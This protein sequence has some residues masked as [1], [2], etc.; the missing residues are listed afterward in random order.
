[1]YMIDVKVR[2][3]FIILN[4]DGLYFYFF[5]KHSIFFYQYVHELI[6]RWRQDRKMVKRHFRCRDIFA[7]VNQI[8]V[9]LVTDSN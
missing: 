7:D 9:I 5:L 8:D 3:D 4:V 6:V 1:M 2:Y